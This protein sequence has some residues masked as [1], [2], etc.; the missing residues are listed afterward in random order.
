MKP[1]FSSLYSMHLIKMND[2]MREKTFEMA[3]AELKPFVN[4]E[5]FVYV[6]FVCVGAV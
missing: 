4:V 2:M 1:L 5:M 3:P 6:N